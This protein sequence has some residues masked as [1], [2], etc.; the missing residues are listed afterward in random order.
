MKIEFLN[1][2][3]LSAAEVLQMEVGTQVSRG[4][5]G[6]KKGLFVS[7]DVTVLISLVGQVQGTVLY[8][9]SYD[10][11]KGLVS[12]ILGQTFAQF[13]ELAQSGI[14]ELAN[15]ITGLS[16]TRLSGAGYASIISVPMLIIGK[17][18]RISTLNIDRI[19]VP[20]LTD[21][22]EIGLDI[23]LRENPDAPAQ[24]A[25]YTSSAPALTM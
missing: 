9:M 4:Q 3:I 22:G 7:N 24:F 21:V 14:A 8:H 10:T 11:A 20:L 12:A 25:S 17:R 23:A 5:I 18:S 6:L 13:D 19:C 15:V 16:S 1:P 2:F